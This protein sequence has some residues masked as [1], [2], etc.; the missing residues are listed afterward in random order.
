MIE[1]TCPDSILTMTITNQ[2][3]GEV[4]TLNYTSGKTSCTKLYIFLEI[5][6]TAKFAPLRFGKIFF[7]V[8]SEIVK[9]LLFSLLPEFSLTFHP[10]LASYPNPLAKLEL[11]GSPTASGLGT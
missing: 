7:Y 6:H 1:T 4:K 5:F 3:A 8:F 10:L 11:S 9:S 2:E